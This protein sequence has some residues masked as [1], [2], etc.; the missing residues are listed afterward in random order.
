MAS[1]SL[2]RILRILGYLLL[3]VSGIIISGILCLLIAAGPGAYMDVCFWGVCGYEAT[4]DLGGVIGLIVFS[5]IV[6]YI[7]V[8]K[9]KVLTE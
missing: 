4:G 2:K 8:A 1:P 7:W 6:V 9:W 5:I 3:S